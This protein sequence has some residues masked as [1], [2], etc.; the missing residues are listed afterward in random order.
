M[1]GFLAVTNPGWYERLAQKQ[2]SQE[3]NFWKPSIKQLKL[4]IGTPFIFKLKAPH[5]AIAGFGYFAG[6][7][8]MPDWLAWDTFGGANGVDSLE[9]LRARLTDIRDHARIER[10]PLGLIGCAMIAEARFFSRANWIEPPTDWKD[11]VQT[12]MTYDLSNGEGERI[13]LE[14]LARGGGTSEAAAVV[15]RDSQRYGP[16]VVHTPRLGQSI[17]RIKVLDAYGRAC[18]ISKEHSL[19]VLEAVHIRPFSQGGEHD[20]ANGMSMRSDIHRL[21]DR[22]YVAVDQDLRTVVS[23][24]LRDDFGN[25]RSYDDYHGRPV[26]VPS[27]ERDRPSQVAL[28]WHRTHVFRG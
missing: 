6:F 21:F 19:P 7:S 1:R 26:S 23:R 16:P 8:V 25:G 11:R 5:H 12:G 18:T 14:C 24:R 15:R 2:E 4:E 13:W 9:A 20:V 22:G 27:A 3:A 10:N 28:E 17:F